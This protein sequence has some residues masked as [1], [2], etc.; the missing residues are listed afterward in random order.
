MYFPPVPGKGQHMAQAL[1][2]GIPINA[3]NRQH[4]QGQ[5]PAVAHQEAPEQP[6]AVPLADHADSGPA[7]LL[8]QGH[9]AHPAAVLPPNRRLHAAP[10]FPAIL[11]PAAAPYAG[12]PRRIF[13]I[14]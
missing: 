5:L 3:H 1:E 14:E 4:A 13:R 11:C 8:P 12:A 9:R 7:P 6:A 10:P 2:Q